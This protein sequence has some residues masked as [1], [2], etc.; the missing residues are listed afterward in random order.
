MK[1][2]L[3]HNVLPT[4]EEIKLY[5]EGKL[6]PGRTHEIELLAEENPMLGDAL[7]GYAALPLFT[8]VPGITAAVGQQATASTAN[9]AIIGAKGIASITKSASSLWQL[10][11]WVIG[12]GAVG[13]SAA[14]VTSIIMKDDNNAES[15]NVKATNNS[16][17]NKEK[18]AEAKNN[19]QIVDYRGE[20]NEPK[21]KE[22]TSNFA[23]ADN[24][25]A[26]SVDITIEGSDLQHT[27]NPEQE[28]AFELP[29]VIE[30]NSL[31]TVEN[32]AS[33]IGE[34]GLRLSNSAVVAI[35]IVTI[36]KHK[37][38]DYTQL[39]KSAW[40][41]V[42]LEEV[43][44]SANYSDYANKESEK[45]TV[46]LQVPYLK[47]IEECIT[48][49]DNQE[50]KTSINGFLTIL[51]QYPDDVNAQFYGAMSYFHHDQPVLALELLEKAEKNPISTFREEIQFY[52]AKCLKMLNRTEE[53]TIIFK[54]IVARNGFYKAQSQKELND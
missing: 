46:K 36:K 9:G 45:A 2:S 34:A 4:A 37:V 21:T 23:V 48:A 50:Y 32:P 7:E 35:S 14:I 49:Y 12:V 29:V 33:S 27:S 54:S 20:V 42:N 47:Y 17:I 51:T 52:K 38:A 25:Q 43:G 11:S 1:R 18:P 3:D 28:K 5:Q 41:K 6:S 19:Q 22:T 15:S 39:R 26:K 44:L 30:G 8:A 24:Q 31:V 40:D 16:T 13:V 53:S 10:N